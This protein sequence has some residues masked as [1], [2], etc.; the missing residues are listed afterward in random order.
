MPNPYLK[1][2]NHLARYKCFNAFIYWK[3][4]CFVFLIP[5]SVHFW[6]FWTFCETTAPYFQWKYK[7]FAVPHPYFKVI[8]HLA[9]FKCFSTFIYWKKQ[10]F[11]YLTPFS[12]HFWTFWTS[13]GTTNPYSHWKY[14]LSAV[15]HPYIKVIND[16]ARF[17]CF[18]TFMYWKK[19]DFVFLCPCSFHLWTSWTSCKTTNHYFQ[20]KYK[21]YV[22]PH[23]YLKVINHLARFK[24]VKKIAAKCHEMNKKQTKQKKT[25]THETSPTLVS[26][27]NRNLSKAKSSINWN[28]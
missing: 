20:W 22:V 12:V 11:M 14:E 16:L 23:P 1:V 24:C 19:P 9:R 28:W 2:I 7:L 6:T 18:S 26:I 10:D 3:K 17:K 25:S 4:C 13:C 27:E 8:N 15:P 21:L 5:F